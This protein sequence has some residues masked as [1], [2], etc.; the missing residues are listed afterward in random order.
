MQVSK[1]GKCPGYKT[2]RCTT[3]EGRPSSYRDGEDDK[4]PLL[5]K[6]DFH[7]FDAIVIHED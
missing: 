4:G 1:H 6:C 3:Q 7:H 5:I 2:C